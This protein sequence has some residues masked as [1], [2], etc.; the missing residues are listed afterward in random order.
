MVTDESHADALG[1]S[2]ADRVD[3]VAHRR[4]RQSLAAHATRHLRL[5]PWLTGSCTWRGL[6][7]ALYGRGPGSRPAPIE[8][9]PR[10]EPRSPECA[11][12]SGAHPTHRPA[13]GY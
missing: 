12:V 6:G 8:P 9:P 13:I 7:S 11:F 5:H 1:T 3:P 10:H 4:N 2:E